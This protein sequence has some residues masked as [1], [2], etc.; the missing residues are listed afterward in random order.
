[1]GNRAVSRLLGGGQPLA[2][3]LRAELEARVGQDLGGVRLH[4]DAAADEMARE[5]GALAFTT[6]SEIGFRAGHYEPGSRRGRRLLAHELSHVVQQRRAGTRLADRSRPGDRH[7]AAAE[8]AASG[9]APAVE[10][11]GPVPALQL[12]ATTGA[13]VPPSST[14]AGAAAAVASAGQ[15]GGS[16]LFERRRGPPTATGMEECV[17]YPTKAEADEAL[18]FLRRTWLTA[19]QARSTALGRLWETYLSG[20]GP[21]QTFA[22]PDPVA[23]SFAGH[24]QSSYGVELM[25]TL[26]PKVEDALV[27]RGI[28]SIRFGERRSFTMQELGLV[29]TTFDWNFGNP[30]TIAGNIAGGIGAGDKGP[31][32]RVLTGGTVTVSQWS[33]GQFWGYMEIEITVHETLDLCPGDP[34]LDVE[35]IFTIPMK[36]LEAGGIAGDV[37]YDVVIPWGH[38]WM[39]YEAMARYRRPDAGVPSGPP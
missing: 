35:R 28:G 18:A 25:R 34:G 27:D 14:D 8:A 11:G 30:L 7:E 17:P 5:L 31:D 13:G 33:P 37:P 12:Q 22:L 6:G 20:G 21:K 16:G 2:G 29:G 39:F 9:N 4:T 24:V 3:H 36:R 23:E 32:S 10:S 1:V 19:A 26:R 38:G 15:V